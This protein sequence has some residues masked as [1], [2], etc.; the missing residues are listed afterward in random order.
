[1][2][3]KDI[4]ILKYLFS[5]S[6]RGRGQTLLAQIVC[7]YVW[8]LSPAETDE[9]SWLACNNFFFFFQFLGVIIDRVMTL[10][11]VLALLPVISLVGWLKLDNSP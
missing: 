6:L 5:D 4:T 7:H 3:Y 2:I 10:C 11:R 9:P 8:S 1:M